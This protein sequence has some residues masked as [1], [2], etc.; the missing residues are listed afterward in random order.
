MSRRSLKKD[1][2]LSCCFLVVG[3]LLSFSFAGCSQPLVSQ[4]LA[5][6]DCKLTVPVIDRKNRSTTIG[7]AHLCSSGTKEW[8]DYTNTTSHDLSAVSICA[9]A[10]NRLGMPSGPPYCRSASVL[11]PEQDL[12]TP[13]FLAQGTYGITSVAVEG[14]VQPTPQK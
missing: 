1:H 2:T 7:L 4:K 14:S 3:I 10:L 6:P 9:R 11:R 5:Q 12:I 8:I 13:Q